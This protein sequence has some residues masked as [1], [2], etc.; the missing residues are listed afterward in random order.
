M[1]T[2]TGSKKVDGALAE[3]ACDSVAFSSDGVSIGLRRYL[4][5]ESDNGSDEK[6]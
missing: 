4:M 6:A 3:A 1:Y 2:A 5:M